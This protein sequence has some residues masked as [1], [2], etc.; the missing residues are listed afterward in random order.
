MMRGEI[1]K[2]YLENTSIA[3]RTVI[4]SLRVGS[5]LIQR[6]VQEL[7]TI[8]HDVSISRKITSEKAGDQARFMSSYMHLIIFI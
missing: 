3:S 7:I 2:R 4:A 1:Y 8:C 6:H 5:C